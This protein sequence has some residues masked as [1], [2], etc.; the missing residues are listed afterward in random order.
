MFDEDEID[1]LLSAIKDAQ[2]E[3]QENIERQ[4]KFDKELED[5]RNGRFGDD[6]FMETLEKQIAD[7]DKQ[8]TDMLKSFERPTRTQ[9]RNDRFDQVMDELDNVRRPSNSKRIH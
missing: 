7:M 5:I 9:R 3:E 8:F 6:D 4:K 1:K 2:R